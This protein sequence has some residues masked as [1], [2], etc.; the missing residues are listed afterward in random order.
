MVALGAMLLALLASG[1]DSTMAQLD[2]G[3]EENGI[4]VHVISSPCQ[5]GKT[6]IRVLLPDKLEPDRRYPVVYVLPVEAARE[7]TYGDGLQEVQHH[8]LHNQHHAIFVAPTFSALPWYA[9]HPG[10][11][12]LRQETYFVKVVVPLIEQRYPAVTESR[13]RLLV[14]FSK[15]GWGAYT[16]LLRHPDLFGRAAAWDAPLMK[17]KPDQFGMGEIF[18]TQANFELYRVSTLLTQRAAELRDNNRLILLGFGNFRQHHVQVHELMVRLGIR[19][20]YR[21][22]PARTHDW[23]SGWLEEAVELLLERARS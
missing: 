2:A 20:E 4:I 13:G 15:S 17:E 7:S 10:D 11:P 14:G 3:R 21:D 23:S 8:G 5:A 16:L 1:D 22:G 19:H 6:E 18:G 12:H 9:D